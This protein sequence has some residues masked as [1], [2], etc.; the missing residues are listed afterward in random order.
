M[1]CP[2]RTGTSGGPPG[3]PRKRRENSFDPKLNGGAFGRPK[4]VHAVG[5]VVGRQPPSWVVTRWTLA[6]CSA[7]ALPDRITSRLLTPPVVTVRLSETPGPGE[8]APG[9]PAG[10]A[11]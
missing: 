10:R 8:T 3:S 1:I 7:V 4:L 2:P 9:C 11:C 5:V 6:F